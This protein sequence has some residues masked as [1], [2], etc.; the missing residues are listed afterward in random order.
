MADMI[1]E[2]EPCDE[3]KMAFAMKDKTVQPKFM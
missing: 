2:E 3:Y 1:G